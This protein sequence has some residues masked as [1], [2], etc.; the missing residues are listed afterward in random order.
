MENF[1]F[2]NQQ[3]AVKEAEGG[4]GQRKKKKINLHTNKTTISQG[5]ND[6]WDLTGV[7]DACMFSWRI[8]YIQSYTN[9]SEEWL[10]TCYFQLRLVF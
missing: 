7:L 5:E 6:L 8:Q 2:D 1:L 4:R 10:L 3:K 9:N